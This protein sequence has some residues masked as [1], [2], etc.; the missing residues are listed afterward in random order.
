[1][2]IPAEYGEP[3][4]YLMCAGRA[5]HM[6]ICRKVV[7]AVALGAAAYAMAQPRNLQLEA[8]VRERTMSQKQYFQA[9]DGDTVLCRTEALVAIDKG[10][11]LPKPCVCDGKPKTSDADKAAL[12]ALR[13]KRAD[14]PHLSWMHGEARLGIGPHTF[15]VVSISAYPVHPLAAAGWLR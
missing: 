11:P 13:K 5:L 2:G 1:M 7:I 8:K 6:G 4:T 9:R 12:V 3:P 15:G 10:Y 14:C